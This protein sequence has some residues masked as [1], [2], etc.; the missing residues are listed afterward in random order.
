MTKKIVTIAGSDSLAGGGIQADLK[1]FEGHNFF[2]LSV[3][4]CIAS[5]KED[6]F[7]IDDLPVSVIEKQLTSILDSTTIDGIKIGLIHQSAAIPIIANHLKD[8]QVPIILDP[9]LAF[10]ETQTIQNQ[11]YMQQLIVELF[12]LATVVT[13]NLA[14]AELLAS[15]PSIQTFKEMEE[16]ATIIHSYG[17]QYV[18]IKGGERFPG[19]LAYDLLFDGQ[20]FTYF[21]K[22]KL[23]T[24]TINGAGCTFA[25]AIAANSLLLDDMKQIITYSKDYVYQAI[26]S[27]ITLNDALGNVWHGDPIL[28]GGT[29]NE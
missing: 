29:S 4:T 28:K 10:K 6:T 22:E 1:T 13:P 23:A 21:E 5:I 17:S 7:D 2:G 19:A 8:L 16:A 20:Q 3:L 9:V 27:G 18:V 14:E 12:P 15:V 24:N 26:Q 11:Q 25:S